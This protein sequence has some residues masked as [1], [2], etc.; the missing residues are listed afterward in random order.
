MKLVFHCLGHIFVGGYL[1]AYLALIS[2]DGFK[3]KDITVAGG[4][5]RGSHEGFLL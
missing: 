3:T 1:V 5:R 4:S 2:V